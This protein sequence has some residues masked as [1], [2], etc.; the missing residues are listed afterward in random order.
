MTVYSNLVSTCRNHSEQPAS[1]RRSDSLDNV[2]VDVV[3]PDHFGR[4]K[5]HKWLSFLGWLRGPVSISQVD[6]LEG[7]W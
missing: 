7:F 1:S 2:C 4:M 3:K 6:R 5:I